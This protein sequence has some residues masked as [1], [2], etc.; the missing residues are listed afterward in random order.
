MLEVKFLELRKFFKSF[1]PFEDLL[2][3]DED[4]WNALD[5][6]QI[7]LDGVSLDDY[8]SYVSPLASVH[9]SAIVKDSYI[10]DNAKIYEFVTV[11]NS[12]IGSGTV[13]GHGTEVA[14]SIILTDCSI[15]RFN[16]IGSSIIGGQVRLGGI[17]SLASR[18]FDDH[19]VTLKDKGKFLETKRFKF[20][21]IIGDKCILGFAVHC[22]PGTVV[23]KNCIIMPHIDLRGRITEDN[24]VLLKQQILVSR[25]RSFRQLGV[26]RLIKPYEETK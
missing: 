14:K 19:D 7:L 2:S 1:V 5:K 26:S 25:K 20:G 18:R 13:I 22:N 11:R 8:G 10:S 24:V 23:E 15:P 4:I 21:S 16:Y 9:P 3:S 6:V 12:F 17:C